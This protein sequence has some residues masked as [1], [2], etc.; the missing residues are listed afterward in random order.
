VE[1]SLHVTGGFAA[2]DYSV[3]FRS[4]TGWLLGESCTNL[5]DFQ[6][7]EVL[8][9][10]SQSEVSYILSL[11]E[12]ADIRSKAGTDFGTQCCDQFYFEVAYSEGDFTSQVEGSS[13]LLPQALREAVVAL[14]AMVMNASPV[15]VD[16]STPADRWPRDLLQIRSAEVLG[17]TLQVSVEYSGGCRVHDVRAVAWGGWMESDPVRVRLFL[18]HEDFDDPCDALIHRDLRFDLASLRTAYRA[19]YGTAPPGETT[20]V[21]LLEDPLMLGPL[22]ARV[23]DYTF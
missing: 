3:T 22:S 16:F 4:A 13:E 6:P 1:I 12:A 2:A 8:Q 10:L 9:Q 14:Q 21:L 18:A 15:V 20:L 5:C 19:A 7:G 17:Q 23:L 11:F